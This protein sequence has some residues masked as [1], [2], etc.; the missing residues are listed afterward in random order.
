[1]FKKYLYYHKLIKEGHYKVLL[2]QIELGN[3]KPNRR[4]VKKLNLLYYQSSLLENWNSIEKDQVNNKF[5]TSLK[6]FIFYQYFPLLSVSIIGTISILFIV[7]TFCNLEKNNLSICK[8]LCFNCIDTNNV[9][10]IDST[11]STG[12]DTKGVDSLT[13]VNIDTLRFRGTINFAKY[14]TQIV[15]KKERIKIKSIENG[16]IRISPINYTN[17]KFIIN[18]ENKIFN[19]L[20]THEVINNADEFLFDLLQIGNYCIY[21]NKFNKSNIYELKIIKKS[22]YFENKLKDIEL[23]NKNKK[24]EELNSLL[25]HKLYYWPNQL[26]QLFRKF[27]ILYISSIKNSKEDYISFIDNIYTISDRP[28][29]KKFSINQKDE[30]FKSWWITLIKIFVNTELNNSKLWESNKHKLQY[31]LSNDSNFKECYEK[32]K[33]KLKTYY[34]D[35]FNLSKID[36][37]FNPPPD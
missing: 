23:S 1:M 32:F 37:K 17:S 7:I 11:D 33:I 2:K 8:H 4:F 31:S 3:I 27:E 13:I 10:K 15:D 25:E 20:I 24:E 9:I 16:Q 12:T 21:P 28:E 34:Q 14:I 35:T 6:K 36:Y 29:F 22:N 18:I 26:F 5:H 19:S 30:F